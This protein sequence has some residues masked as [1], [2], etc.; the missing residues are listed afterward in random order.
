MC[1]ETNQRP[2]ISNYVALSTASLWYTNDS[3]YEKE[4]SLKCYV[5]AFG[6]HSRKYEHWIAIH[7]ILFCVYDG[8]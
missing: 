3:K 8:R 7:S 6:G 4:N 5:Q 2:S 1:M